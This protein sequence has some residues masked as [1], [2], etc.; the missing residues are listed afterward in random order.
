[1]IEC[2]IGAGE[3]HLRALGSA[4]ATGVP[5]A[6]GTDMLPAEPYEGTSATVASSSTTSARG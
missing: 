5:V 4:I 6:C 1:M 2:A 3:G